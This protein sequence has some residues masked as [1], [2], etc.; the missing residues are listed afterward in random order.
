MQSKQRVQFHDRT[1][2]LSAALKDG[3][4]HDSQ[5]VTKGNESGDVDDVLRVVP[6][7]R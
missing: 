2:T 6:Q 1:A 4:S 3:P 5:V 7:M